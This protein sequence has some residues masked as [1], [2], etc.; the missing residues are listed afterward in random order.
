MQNHASQQLSCF[1]IPENSI[2]RVGFP[3]AIH[4]IYDYRIPEIFMGKVHPGMPVQVEVKNRKIWG[5]AVQIVSSSEFPKLKE[6]LDIKTEHWTDSNTSLIRL[7]EWISAYYHCDLGRVFRPIVSKGILA[8]SSKTLFFYTAVPRETDGLKPQYIQPY[9]ELLVKG[10]VTKTDAVEKIG[11]KGSV[12]DYLLKHGYIVREKKVVLREA[13]ELTVDCSALKIVLSDEQLQAVET[14]FAEFDNP[15]KPFLIHGITGSGKTHIYIELS[16]RVLKAGKSIIILVPEISLT[17]QTIQRFKSELGDVIAVIH[18]NM[19]DGERRDSLQELVTGNKKMVI[20]VR[21][22]V[23]A[24]VD[25]VGLII[26]DEEHDQSY[27]QS[28][29]EPRYNARDVAVMRGHFQKA[30]VVLG[31]ATP[32]MESYYNTINGKYAIVRLIRRFGGAQLPAVE[33]V[34]MVREHA[35]NN[36]SPFSV[37]LVELMKECI[38]SQRQIILLLNRRGYSTVLVCKE[39]G[40]TTSCPNCSVNLRYHRVDNTVKCHLCGFEHRAPDLCPKCGGTKIKYQGTGIQKIEQILHEML[41]GVR[42]LRMD[43]DTTRRKGSHITILNEF[44]ERNADILLGT[45]M[46]AKGLNFPGVA[47]V[48]VIQA[49]SGLHFPDFRASERTFQLLTQ[50]AGRAGRADNL[51]KVVIQ[52]YNPEEIAIKSASMHD[53]ECFFTTELSMREELNY[54]PFSK[55][56]RIIVEGKNESSVITFSESISRQ[57]LE[58]ARNGLTVLGPAP[59]VLE[60][61]DNE[62]RY[63]LLIKA[64]NAQLL[65]TVLS[66]IWHKSTAHSSS[67]RTIIDIDPVNML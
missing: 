11:I 35:K 18:S 29:M 67:I 44:S 64:P 57:L 2:V 30:L 59:A 10:A 43:Q 62:T 61:I 3:I 26:V 51:G 27:K 15:G 36:W 31:S 13:D 58:T 16:R 52:T 32:S 4:G 53:Y 1:T 48:G 47:L 24:P 21:S 50:V 25:N 54:P 6:I 56:A 9:Q 5:V 49:D 66:E 23:L 38:N 41:P 63:S 33:I 37:R 14:I 65:N 22:A 42:I 19:S 28:D 60:K 40:H 46:V 55:L 8:S 7:Y 20:G 39:C 34:D 12:L 45:Q 17:P